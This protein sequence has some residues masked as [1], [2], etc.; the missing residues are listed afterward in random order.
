MVRTLI[1]PDNQDISIKVPQSYIGKR[2]EII[3]FTV[4]ETM[5]EISVMKEPLLTYLASEKSLEKDW[6]KPEEDLAW[7]DL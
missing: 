7:Q 2:V 3:A 1:T 6:L 5:E 4:E